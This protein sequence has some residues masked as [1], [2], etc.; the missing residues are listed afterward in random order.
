MAGGGEALRRRGVTEVTMGTSSGPTPADLTPKAERLAKLRARK[1]DLETLLAAKNDLLKRLCA[2]EAAL[3]GRMTPDAAIPSPTALQ[4]QSIT[5]QQQ[6]QQQHLQQPQFV[7]QLHQQQQQQPQS[8]PHHSRHKEAIPAPHRKPLAHRLSTP[9]TSNVNLQP[10]P[11]PPHASSNV[12]S[13]HHTVTTEHITKLYYS[14][15]HPETKHFSRVHETHISSSHPDI[16]THHTH[17]LMSQERQSVDTLPLL[18]QYASQLKARSPHL[19]GLPHVSSSH[20]QKKRESSRRNTLQRTQT[21]HLTSHSDYNNYLESVPGVVSQSTTHKHVQTFVEAPMVVP[22]TK[23]NYTDQYCGQ[24]NQSYHSAQLSPPSISSSQ[25]IN[26]MNTY[27]P[28]SYTNQCNDAQDQKVKEKE[29]YESSLDSPSSVNVGLNLSRESYGSLKKPLQ[30]SPSVSQPRSSPDSNFNVNVDN[31]YTM[32]SP[33]NS[34]G[35]LSPRSQTSND[36]P[37]ES[38]KNCT[39]VESGKWIPYRE[40]SKPFEMSDFYKYSTKFRQNNNGNQ[41]PKVMPCNPMPSMHMQSD[42]LQPQ[43]PQEH[44]KSQY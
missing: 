21:Y 30:R 31:H 5:Q 40:V 26:Y 28:N 19:S 12:H 22:N 6:Q 2:R 27:S 42:E 16:A 39:V 18:Y 44:W 10:P 15:R 33:T 14:S 11:P 24:S 20:G 1:R 4:A 23:R 25:Q 38:P 3:T 36:L 37:F 34:Q 43:P 7:S 32:L 8:V 13:R 9:S 41:K 29:W 17:M 35:A